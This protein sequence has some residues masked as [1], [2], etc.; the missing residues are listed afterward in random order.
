MAMA[1][2]KATAARGAPGSRRPAAPRP[3]LAVIE[4]GSNRS[5]P[6]KVGPQAFTQTSRASHAKVSG[7]TLGGA[8]RIGHRGRVAVCLSAIALS[9]FFI[10]GLV[11]V[12]I[13]VAQTSFRLN[14]LQ[15]QVVAQQNTY[16]R[17]R[18]EV[19]LAASPARLSDVARKIG[20][21]TPAHQETLTGRPETAGGQ[22]KTGGPAVLTE[23]KLKAL[24]TGEA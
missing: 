2:R 8:K 14:E 11:L 1:A 23:G 12:N 7:A 3:R 18:Y 9:A 10:F 24:L 16:R 5:R 15:K 4:G 13:Y 6:S 19:S 22:A 21:V 17:L 20:L